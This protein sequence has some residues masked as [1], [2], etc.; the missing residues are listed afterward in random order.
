M[1]GS[2]G[3]LNEKF[4]EALPRI[5]CDPLVP[6]LTFCA[7]GR[8]GLFRDSPGLRDRQRLALYVRRFNHPYLDNGPVPMIFRLM[9]MI[10]LKAPSPS[11]DRHRF[12][13]R[14]EDP[15]RMAS[16]LRSGVV[17]KSPVFPSG[18]LRGNA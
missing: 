12:V 9:P 6:W 4:A 14:V 1:R 7:G 2:Q 13:R 18:I 16:V 5:T 3:V 8:H 15:A 10:W 11:V 17:L